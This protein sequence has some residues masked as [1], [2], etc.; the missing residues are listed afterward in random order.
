MLNEGK[1]QEKAC[2]IQLERSLQGDHGKTWLVP[3]RGLTEFRSLAECRPQGALCY[4]HRHL[5]SLGT[6]YSHSPPSSVLL[7][8]PQSVKNLRLGLWVQPRLIECFQLACQNRNK[9]GSL[10]PLF[11]FCLV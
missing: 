10:E 7:I 9:S 1:E 4:K 6:P 8:H 5:P 11:Q 3:I 2:V